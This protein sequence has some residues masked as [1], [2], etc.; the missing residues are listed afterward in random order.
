MRRRR[1]LAPQLVALVAA[2]TCAG[3]IAAVIPVQSAGAAATTLYAAPAVAGTGSCVDAAD[4]CQLQT[5]LNTAV[6]GDTI[7]LANGTYS[8]SNYT[9]AVSVTIQAGPGATEPYIQGNGTPGT[10]FTVEAGVT[11]TLFQFSLGGAFVSGVQGIAN[12]GNLTI[13]NGFIFQ[14][15]NPQGDGGG[16]YD[17]PGANLTMSNST[18]TE[19]SALQGAGIF[20]GQSGTAIP[21]TSVTIISCVIN[22]NTTSGSGANGG[23]ITNYGGTL[24]LK[25]TSLL[26]NS[27]SGAGGAMAAYG[28][29]TANSSTF[30]GNT[31]SI[32]GAISAGFG[33]IENSTF[34]QNT[35]TAGA[36]ST[37][38]GGAIE[39]GTVNLYIVSSTFDDN[40]TDGA[41]GDTLATIP[42]QGGAIIVAATIIGQPTDAGPSSG[43]ECAGT[44]TDDGYTDVDDGSCNLVGPRSFAFSGINDYLG[45]YG[46][47]GGPTPTVP[48][49][50]N[51]KTPIVAPN[52]ALVDIPSTFSAPLQYQAQ[53]YVPCAHP[54]QRGIPRP[55]NGCDGGAYEATQVTSVNITS[56]R[57]QTSPGFPV[58]YTATVNPSPPYGTVTFNDGTGNPATNNCSAQPLVGG[59]ATCT[60]T[61]QS[62]GRYGVG[63]FFH[64]G[65]PGFAAS[66]SVG[67]YLEEVTEGLVY[68]SP[69]GTG[70]VCNSQSPCSLQTAFNVRIGGVKVVLFGG[71]YSGNFVDFA[72]ESI[73]PLPGAG[74][75]IL[76]GGGTGTVLTLNANNSTIVSGVEITDGGGTQIGGA[77]PLV[78]GGIINNGTLM[79]ENST[80]SGNT[81]TGQGGGIYNAASGV[82]TVLQSTISGNAA[83]SG[84]GIY[85]T[86]PGQVLMDDSTVAGNTASNQGG[87]IF[88]AEGGVLGIESSSLIGNSAAAAG[89]GAIYNAGSGSSAASI[90]ARGS[91]QE[92]AGTAPIDAGYDIDDDGTC[93]FNAPGSISNSPAISDYLGSLQD[94][95][96]PTQTVALLPTSQATQLPD[97]A[98]AAIPGSFNLPDA[99]V[100]CSTNDQRGAHRIAPCAIGSFELRKTVVSITTDKEQATPG[101]DLTFTAKVSPIP[102]GGT[103]SFFDGA[104][105]PAQTKC[106]A[107]PLSA[108]SVATCT[109]SYGTAANYDVGA[110]FSGDRNFSAGDTATPVRVVVSK[111]PTTVVLAASKTAVMPGEKVTYT[112]V[113]APAQSGG[114]VSFFD[115]AGNPATTSCPDVPLSQQPGALTATCTVSY[116]VGG[117]YDVKATYAGD[118]TYSP[119]TSNTT[120]VLVQSTGPTRTPTTTGL[121][122]SSTSLANAAPVTLK[123]VVAPVPNGGTVTFEDNGKQIA[124]CTALAVQSGGAKCTV[125]L[126][127]GPHSV[128]ASYSGNSKFAPSVSP[129]VAI[130]VASPANGY[131]LADA[132]GDVFAFGDA[133]FLGSLSVRRGPAPAPRASVVGMAAVPAGDGYWLVDSKGNVNAFG[134]AKPYGSLGRTKLRSPIVGM[135]ATPDGKGYWLVAGDGGVFAFGDARFLGSMVG[136]HHAGSIVGIAVT[137][138][139]KGYWL[140]ASDG[141]VFTYGDAHF[142]G[143][144]ISKHLRASVVGLAV[145]ADGHGYWLVGGDGGVFTFGDAHFHGSLGRAQLVQPVAGVAADPATGGYWLVSGNGAVFSFDAP[146]E[147]SLADV[148][149]VSRE[150]AITVP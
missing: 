102:D 135:A 30:Q 29:L 14:N 50:I 121:S 15:V 53:P 94:N 112:A 34:V 19:N 24:T 109:V 116:K 119:A 20:E 105:N 44:I 72:G 66:G 45:N 43:T 52:V 114:T 54:D 67:G 77:G 11:T 98:L 10:I 101:E 37:I 6:S 100:A 122:A 68:A 88:N 150:V 107:V 87:G 80:V 8:D 73:V 4:A 146:F 21:P 76:S 36:Q 46:D 83:A 81:V 93:G 75:P 147:G 115:G 95:G 26:D 90:F 118:A 7:D 129:A 103:V 111:V 84:A 58:T 61:Y 16:I 12:F 134:S 33:Y 38:G 108:A 39:E 125:V 124:R 142:Y 35:S 32:G 25:Q 59:I 128:F 143:S 60:V 117:L 18:V 149:P 55:A 131:W 126:S 27:T 71:T 56:S 79:L 86:N 3:S 140:A 92:C 49:L 127:S 2:A 63:A 138:D 96:G 144:M 148:A 9:D 65:V 104:G 106:Q 74:T 22:G 113:V 99:H 110:G 130:A 120:P 42:G 70:T 123:A 64:G 91:G 41:P 47:N 136:H 13:G 40:L 17:A 141:G 69:L 5:A 85:N 133:P 139:G 1:R 132:A 137:R 145:P 82:L 51:A 78:G 62:P 57:A 89:G 31:A 48:L 97:P 28:V 23:G